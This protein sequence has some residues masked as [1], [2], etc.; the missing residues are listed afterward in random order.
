MLGPTGL[1]ETF[2]EGFQLPLPPAKQVHSFLPNFAN[3]L[4][5]FLPVSLHV[6]LPDN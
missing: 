6:A 2:R 4:A 5:N 1:P 3:F